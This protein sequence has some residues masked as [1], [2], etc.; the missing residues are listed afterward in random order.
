MPTPCV[1]GRRPPGVKVRMFVSQGWPAARPSGSELSSSPSFAKAL[2][3][4]RTAAMRATAAMAFMPLLQLAWPAGSRSAHRARDA[5]RVGLRDVR[6]ESQQQVAP[7][8][9]ERVGG[10]PRRVA[11][12]RAV[13]ISVHKDVRLAC[14]PD[15]ALPVHG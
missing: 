11:L 9:Q 14:D 13:A 12:H 7:P 3:G 6:L 10:Q 5:Q 15:A 8:P 1:A 4:T 2:D